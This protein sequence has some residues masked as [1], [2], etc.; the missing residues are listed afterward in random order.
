MFLFLIRA[1]GL[2]VVCV[3]RVQIGEFVLPE[4]T[5]QTAEFG[6]ERPGRTAIAAVVAAAAFYLSR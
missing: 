2:R 1:T 4:G 5:R 3:R 6:V